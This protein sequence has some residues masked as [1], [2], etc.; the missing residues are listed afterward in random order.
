MDRKVRRNKNQ[1]YYCTECEEDTVD[2]KPPANEPNEIRRRCRVCR[3]ETIFAPTEEG[4]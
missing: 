3:R 4:W 1:K 2:H